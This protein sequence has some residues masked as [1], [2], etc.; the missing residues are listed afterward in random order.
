MLY[1]IQCWKLNGGCHGLRSP[2]SY[3]FLSLK[4]ALGW[5][6]KILI[7]FFSK[8]LYVEQNTQHWCW[9]LPISGCQGLRIPFSNTLLSLKLALRVVSENTNVFSEVFY[10][11]HNTQNSC[12]E[13]SKLWIP[14]HQDSIFKHSLEPEGE[15]LRAISKNTNNAFSKGLCIDQNTQSSC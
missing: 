11:E 3:T 12:L 5:Y 4:Q 6:Q 8:G 1:K 14:G 2:F 7:M 9:K 15:A 13:A 10:I